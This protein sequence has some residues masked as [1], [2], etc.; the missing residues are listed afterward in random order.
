MEFSLRELHGVPGLCPWNYSWPEH[1]KTRSGAQATTHVTA[2]RLASCMEYADL[3]GACLVC[4][5][6]ER[7]MWYL[8][9]TQAGNTEVG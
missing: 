2:R 3:R 1:L 5:T 9:R 8:A 4:D 6:S 7:N